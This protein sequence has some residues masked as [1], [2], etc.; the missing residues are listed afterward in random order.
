MLW[1]KFRADQRWLWIL[2]DNA[3][4]YQIRNRAKV[5]KLQNSLEMYK[6]NKSEQEAGTGKGEFGEQVRTCSALL[7]RYSRPLSPPH[8]ATVKNKRTL[9]IVF[10]LFSLCLISL[11]NFRLLTQTTFHAVYMY[12]Y[13]CVS[14]CSLSLDIIVCS[15]CMCAMGGGGVG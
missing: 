13:V 11:S 1:S 3:G 12:V 2:T 15:V 8:P 10:K 9:D 4:K 14:I 7:L 6:T 5:F